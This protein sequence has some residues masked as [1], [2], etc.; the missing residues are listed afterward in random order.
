MVGAR[1]S[2]APLITPARGASLEPLCDPISKENCPTRQI[3]ARRSGPI[4]VVSSNVP[5]AVTLPIRPTK[6]FDRRGQAAPKQTIEKESK[7]RILI[8][9]I[10]YSPEPTGIGK[11]TGEMVDWLA[12]RGH[13]FKI[14]VP[15]PYYPHWKVFKGHS[16]WRYV[17]EREDGVDIFRCP[18]WMPSKQSGLGR[19]LLQ[20][21]FV[22]TSTPLMLWLAKTWHPEIVLTLMPP[23]GGLPTALAASSLSGAVSWMHVQDFE[24]DVAFSL[25]ILKGQTWRRRAIKLERFLVA[26]FDRVSSITPRMVD[27]LIKKGI[28]SDK[29]RLFSNWVDTEQIFP[30]ARDSSYRAELDISPRQIVALY[31]G[32]LGEKQGLEILVDVAKLITAHTN[33]QIVICGDG[34][35]REHLLQL[36]NGI[37]NIRFLPVQPKER[38]NDLLNLG[39]IHLLPQRFEVADLVMPS[40]LCGMLASGRPVVAGA[41]E[42]TQIARE[43]LF[44]GIVVPPEDSVAMARALLELS[45]D[46]LRRKQLGVAARERS[47]DQ[48]KKTNILTSF[49]RELSAARPRP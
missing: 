11:V 32:N 6:T 5:L 37:N 2:A 39:D 46:P 48:W 17:I 15:P 28:P 22:L 23:M 40:K 25:G 19:L 27:A 3:R 24:I 18:V 45:S 30:L 21:S 42:D 16:N 35:G 8:Y 36:A 34:V 33:I 26:K 14:V 9:S 12:S 29:C 43:V 47:L 20:A 38:L 4:N 1:G 41:S 7:L 31:S 13:K 10:F 44:C 49:E